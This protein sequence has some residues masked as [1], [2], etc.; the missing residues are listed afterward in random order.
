MNDFQKRF[1][2]FMIGCLG[3]R[4]ALAYATKIINPD[5]LP[6]IGIIILFGAIRFIYLFFTNPT[7][8]QF[9]GKDIWWNNVRPL[10][11]VFYL[12]FAVSAIMKKSYAWIFLLLDVILALV[13]FLV[14]HFVINNDFKA[15]VG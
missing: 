2:M 8:P 10:H 15:L 5:Y 9:L 13:S 11:F 3:A 6:Y 7:G 14:Y 12:L 1:L 4:S